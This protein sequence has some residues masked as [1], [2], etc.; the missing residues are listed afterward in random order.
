MQAFSD[1]EL[2]IYPFEKTSMTAVLGR[3]SYCAAEG[4]KSTE[5]PKELRVGKKERPMV[6]GAQSVEGVYQSSL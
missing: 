4:L 6:A 2:V 1:Y 5:K 3:C